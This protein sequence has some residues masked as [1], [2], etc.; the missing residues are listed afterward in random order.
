MLI[1]YDLTGIDF[2]E[3]FFGWRHCLAKLLHAELRH[4][5]QIHTYQILRIGKILTICV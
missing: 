3:R 4:G 1:N 2:K 5:A